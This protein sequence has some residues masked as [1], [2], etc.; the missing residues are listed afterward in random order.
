MAMMA[1]TVTVDPV[2]VAAATDSRPICPPIFCPST[3]V[4]ELLMT[5]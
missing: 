4:K 3:K 1:V 5:C 2:D